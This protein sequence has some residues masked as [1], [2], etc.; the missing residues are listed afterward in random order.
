MLNCCFMNPRNL[1]L[2]LLLA[3]PPLVQADPNWPWMPQAPALR[4]PKDKTVHVADVDAL[5]KAVEN[6]APGATILVADGHYALPRFLVVRTSNVTLRGASGDRNKVVF[7]GSKLK[8]GEAVGVYGASDVTFAHFTVRNVKW[9]GIKIGAEKGGV[10]RIRVY[11]CVLHN[12]WQRGV[13]GA[14]VP[15]DKVDTF[16]PKNCKIQHCLFY[17]DRPKRFEDDP[18]DNPKTYNGNYIG[19]IDVKCTVDW[20][21]S[22]NVFMNIQGRTREGRA[23]I[24][25]SENGRGCVLERNIFINC[26]IGIG[27]G[28]PTLGDAPLRAIDCV[29]RHNFVLNCP[30]TGI[31]SCYTKNC[32]IEYNT[33]HEPN[34]R[35]RRLLWVQKTNEGLKLKGNLLSGHGIKITSKSKI[36]NEDTVTRKDLTVFFVDTPN[37]NLNLINPKAFPAGAVIPLTQK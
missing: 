27:L 18:T 37:G 5:F 24:Y 14:A 3:I 2:C 1:M 9:N 11:D 4:T 28:N 22:D 15:K 30:E 8:H 17:N 25:I 32:R 34:S 31:L 36:Q 12:I 26:D 16:S 35:M 7:D 21:I 13:K 19:G 33:V 6:A 20:V 29:V 10:H 23:G